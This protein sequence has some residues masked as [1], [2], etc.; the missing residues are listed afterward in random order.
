MPRSGEESF[1]AERGKF[2][3][4]L[5]K[6]IP[7]ALYCDMSKSRVPQPGGI[8]HQAFGPGRDLAA[9]NWPALQIIRQ[10][11]GKKIHRQRLG[12]VLTAR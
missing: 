11:T 7:H 10:I 3:T 12:A 1:T 5:H 2:G 6:K 8:Q 9:A 4:A